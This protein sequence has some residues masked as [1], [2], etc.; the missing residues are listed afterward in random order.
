[1]PTLDIA[2]VGC[3]RMGRIRALGAV[4]LGA[5]VRAVFDNDAARAHQLANAL[6]DC[7]IGS[8]SDDSDW[9]SFDA[10]FVCTPPAERRSAHQAILQGVPTFMEKPIGIH[11]SDAASLVRAA[12]RLHVLTAVGYMNRYRDTI[13]M[14]R[15][16]LRC[17]TLLGASAHWVNGTYGVPWWTSSG[18]SGGSLNEQATH[19]VDLFRYLLGEPHAVHAMATLHP[20]HPGIVGNA[21]LSLSFADGVL[22]TLLYS[23]RAQAKAIG[24]H[25]FTS[26]GEM[27]LQDW[28]FHAV[29]V[30]QPTPNGMALEQ[31][32]NQIF[33][34]ETGA[35]LSAVTT[36]NASFIRC[37][38]ADALQTQ[39]VLDA[40]GQSLM[41][42]CACPV[43]MDDEPG[44]QANH[45]ASRV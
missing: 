27:V 41:S 39:R 17:S 11:A 22:A 15:Q 30:Q 38:L 23:C 16:Q 25:L 2:I 26:A 5:A 33:D 45:P 18:V 36:G 42:G 14:A 24:L 43:R 34:T 44:S 40:A 19:V 3:G 32:K 13:A 10:V 29:G 37:T 31:D 21:A 6:P 7:R 9:S 20:Q 4:R 8:L 28:N 12:E 1:M 35:F